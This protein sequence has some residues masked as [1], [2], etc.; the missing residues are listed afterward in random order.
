MKAVVQRVDS[1]RVTV[2][3]K[4]VGEIGKGHLVLLGVEKEDTRGDAEYLADKIANLR[5]FEDESGKMNLSLLDI[6][7]A[8]LVVSQFTLLADCSKGRRPSFTQA[9]EPSL[10]QKLYEH[11][12]SAAKEKVEKV[13]TGEFQ[14]MMK[15]VLV[16]NGP[17]TMILESRR[18]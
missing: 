2:G 17:V 6:K 4:T 18:S 13:E 8:M 1:A 5:I 7:G 15:I 16:N 12:V 14:E 11:F 3:E 10:A 9:G